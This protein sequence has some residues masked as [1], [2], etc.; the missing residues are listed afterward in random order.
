VQVLDEEEELIKW[1]CKAESI[2]AEVAVSTQKTRAEYAAKAAGSLP[3]AM[4]LLLLLSL[5]FLT[6]FRRQGR[7][8]EAAAERQAAPS[9]A[10]SNRRMQRSNVSNVLHN[11]FCRCFCVL[12]IEQLIACC[13][14]SPPTGWQ[15]SI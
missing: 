12:C 8:H 11:L 14:Y 3:P 13:C 10:A 15:R 2:A 7:L 9:V 6:L 5:A 1:Y 4:L